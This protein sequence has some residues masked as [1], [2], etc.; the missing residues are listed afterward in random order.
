MLALLK[1]LHSGLVTAFRLRTG[2]LGL[3]AGTL[4]LGREALGVQ[5]LE[6]LLFDQLLLAQLPDFRLHLPPAAAQFF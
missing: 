4:L 2:V 3:F 6:L 5:L 1:L